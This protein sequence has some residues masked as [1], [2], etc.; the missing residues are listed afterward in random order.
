MRA[1]RR[2]PL[3]T[4]A[5]FAAKDP[6]RPAVI[7]GN[8]DAI[9]TYGEL[10]QRSR[11][12]ALALRE[13]GLKPGDGVVAL[14][15]NQEGFF[16]V[17][18]ACFRSG[19]F[20]TPVNWHLAEREI[21]YVV[22]NCDAKVFI[23]SSQF[24]DMAASVAQKVPALKLRI[25]ID[26]KF[27]GFEDLQDLVAEIAPDAP[28]ENQLE[29]SM[30]LYSSGTT[31]FPKG[32]RHPLPNKAAGDPA[33]VGTTIGM[34]MLFGMDEG[35]RYICPAPLYHAAPL[36]F[37]TAQHRMG[38]TVVLMERFD[39][40]DA[41]RM[42]QDQKVTASQWVPTHFKRLLSLPDEVRSKY[43]LS[44]LKLA[45]H[46]A[47]PCPVPVKHA[48]IEWWGEIIQEY[49]AG[50]EGGGTLIRSEEWLSH[51]GSVG[52]HW[53]GGTIHILDDEDNEIESPGREGAIY[54]E[55]PPD[56]AARFKYYKD[57]EKTAN[58]YRDNLFTIGD[59]GYLDEEGFLFLT[60]RKSH[61]I[62][63]GGV[64]IYPQETEN[65]LTSHAKVADVAVIGV[66]NEEMGEEVKAVVVPSDAAAAGEAL[67]DEL[68]EYCRAGIAHYKCPR[69]IDFV[70]ELPRLPNGKLL[71]RKLREQ[72][73]EGEGKVI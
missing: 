59:I 33:A 16:D 14:L 50:T 54:F 57:D 36:A 21:E 45:I 7:Y 52:R 71:K 26:K 19:L 43:D 72:Y 15:G 70:T 20:F 6:D 37:S 55:A 73:W 12:I 8:G 10:E 41:L 51:P 31:G 69:S 30:M 22:D 46:A 11:Q 64:N 49:Y 67:R 5:N 35:E 48:M 32:V 25:S 39:P 1:Q 34:M 42:I 63:S 27:D 3:T 23:T 60:D 68:M 47:A 56:P 29:G 61:M 9:E 17:Y 66:P 58:T 44:S 40:E 4:V 65:H 62:I 2:T 38:S 24:E 53:A 18:W 13:K 28:F